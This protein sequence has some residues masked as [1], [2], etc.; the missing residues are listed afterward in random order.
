[1]LH[2][3]K[4]DFNDVLKPRTK[5]DYIIL[6]HSGVKARHT[7]SDIHQWHK[8]KGWAGIGYHY[9][10][11]KEGKIYECRPRDTVGAHAKGYNKNSIGVC[12]EGDFN[13]ETMTDAQCSDEV[14]RFLFFLGLTYLDSKFVFCD[15]LKKRPVPT[16]IKGFRKDELWKQYG[17]FSDGFHSER[18]RVW[19][20]EWAQT[21][22][23]WW[24]SQLIDFGLYEPNEDDI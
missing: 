22:Y 24:D 19:G 9:F 8:N 23:D 18:G 15:E 6:H 3:L 5:T 1:M 10:I 14:I 4:L 21:F 17:I 7:A 20:E 12:F 2:Q 16:A 13:K 11:D